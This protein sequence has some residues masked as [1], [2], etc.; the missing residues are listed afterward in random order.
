M[1]DTRRRQRAQRPETPNHPTEKPTVKT[2]LPSIASVRSAL[3]R[4]WTY[5]RRS[6]VRSELV[7]RGEDFAGT[8]IRLQ[9]Y[10]SGSWSLHSGP[11]DY[12]QDHNGYWG[13]S[14]LSYDRQNLTDLARDLIDQCAESMAMESE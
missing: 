7:E 10:P 5:L 8:D 9:V 3:A 6:F 12:D 4:E 13:A 2:K 1:C 14:C 11:A